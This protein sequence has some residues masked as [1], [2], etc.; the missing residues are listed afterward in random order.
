MGLPSGND[1]QFVIE[2]GPVELSWV[3][4]IAFGANYQ[5]VHVLGKKR[6]LPLSGKDW[7]I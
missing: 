4:L 6:I 7:E 2:N 5:R 3:P 1:S